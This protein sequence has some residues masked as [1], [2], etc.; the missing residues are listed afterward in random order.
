MS[1]R[2]RQSRRPAAFHLAATP[3]GLGGARCVA[4]GALVRRNPRQDTLLGR[5]AGR[6]S[7]KVDREAL[8]PLFAFGFG[9]SYTHFEYQS[10]ALTPAADG[11]LDVSFTLSNIGQARGDEVSQVYLTAP[12]P[13]S[14]QAQFA[15]RSLVAFTRITLNPHQSKRVRLHLPLHRLQYWSEPDH[16]WQLAAGRRSIQVGELIQ[17]YPLDRADRLERRRWRIFPTLHNRRP[18]LAADCSRVPKHQAFQ[19]AEHVE[20]HR[21]AVA[22]AGHGRRC[23]GGREALQGRTGH[24]RRLDPG[25]GRQDVRLHQLS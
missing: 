5:A 8:E 9:L 16:R 18:V 7:L 21:S 10:L 25:Q 17:G 2:S 6:L 12:D 11:G 15:D 22:F 13:L 3:R 14:H 4:P 20:T 23:H 1:A 24:Q 19:G